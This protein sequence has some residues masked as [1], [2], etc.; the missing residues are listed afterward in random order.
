[1]VTGSVNQCT[2]EAGTSDAVKDLLAGIDVQD[3]VYA[4]AGDLFEAGSRAQVVRRGTLFPGHANK[5]YQLYRQLRG[6]HELDPATRRAI[7]E[8]YFRRSFDEVWQ[9]T[10]A[11]LRRN[12]PRDLER[13]EKDP[14]ARMA[15]VFRWYFIHANRLALSGDTGDRANYQIH[16]GPALGAFNRCVAGTALSPWRERHVDLIAELLMSGAAE[17]LTAWLADV[18]PDA[19]GASGP[20]REERHA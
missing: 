17:Y 4:P 20:A 5:L 16:C 1:V 2:P 7:E 12:R 10:S 13:A 8:R 15:Q 3:T 6:L 19:V 18:G 11:Y 9:E 14:K